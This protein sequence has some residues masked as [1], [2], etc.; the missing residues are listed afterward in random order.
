MIVHI[1]GRI[2][3]KHPTR[4]VLDVGGVG[5]ELLIPLSS[6][7]DLPLVDEKCR[8]LT[9]DHVRE[10]Q[11]TL[12]GFKTESERRMF[13][14]LT[15]VSGIGPKL[16]LS[17]L[18][19]LSVRDLNGAVVSGDIPR[20]TTI[21]GVAKKTAE[22]IIVE[23]RDKIGEGDGIDT[24]EG[25]GT[26]EDAVSRDAVMALVSLGYKQQAARKLVDA[27]TAANPTLSNV[28]EVIRK[29]LAR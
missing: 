26:P 5:Y 7:E 13:L 4:V 22:R 10:D 28:E 20:L 29:A 19:G 23:L 14:M 11:H 2:T 1:E 24:S 27:A 17:A 9:V 16:A 3:E 21:S 18:S 25:G 8:L 15:S 6:Y 12:Y